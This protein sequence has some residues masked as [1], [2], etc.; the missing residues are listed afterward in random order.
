MD[1][2]IRYSR[3]CWSAGARWTRR[4]TRTAWGQRRPRY[5]IHVC[6]QCQPLYLSLVSFA[7]HVFCRRHCAFSQS[8]CAC[9][10]LVLVICTCMFSRLVLS[11]ALS[12]LS[13]S[14]PAPLSPSFLEIQCRNTGYPRGTRQSRPTRTNGKRRA[15]GTD[16]V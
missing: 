1:G 15:T 2:S 4:L 11:V 5:R 3:A 13:S 10:V 16:G 14:N 12:P 7:A 8:P 9:P 6:C